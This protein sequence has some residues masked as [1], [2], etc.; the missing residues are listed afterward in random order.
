MNFRV[1]L[2][3]LHFV[4]ENA[5][6]RPSAAKRMAMCIDAAL[7]R[8]LWNQLLDI[9]EDNPE[10]LPDVKENVRLRLIHDF[11]ELANDKRIQRLFT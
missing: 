7:A 2:K 10:I 6:Y 5:I 8:T 4:F 11:P 1:R 9:F 3:T